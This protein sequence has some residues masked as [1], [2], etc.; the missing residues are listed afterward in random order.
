MAK[1][2]L[3]KSQISEVIAF[4]IA[5][6]AVLS[7]MWWYNNYSVPDD[8]I[9]DAGGSTG[10]IMHPGDSIH[11]SATPVDLPGIDYIQET[12]SNSLAVHYSDNTTEER[13]TYYSPKWQQIGLNAQGELVE[14]TISVR[15]I[16]LFIIADHTCIL[17]P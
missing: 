3:R 9:C 11:F 15:E 2:R 4:V 5:S 7:Y 12:S 16:K 14:E 1:E 17:L 6:T 8:R 13:P 10:H